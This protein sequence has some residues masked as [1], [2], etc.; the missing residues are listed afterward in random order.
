MKP[1]SF[2]QS[3]F[4]AIA[5]LAG[6]AR[7][8]D[9]FNNFSSFN[10]GEMNG[11][12]G[13]SASDP[14]A[15]A[16]AIINIGGAFGS[17]AASLGYVAP[18]LNDYVY[19]SHAASTPLVGGVNAGFSVL[20][21]VIDSDSGYNEPLADPPL[22]GAETR[23]TFGFRLEN[24]SGA[25]L[26]SLFLVPYAQHPTPE[27]DTA[28]H[29]FSWSTGD[30]TPTTVL[31]P[32]TAQETHAYTFKIDFEPSGVNDVSFVANI[33]G[34][35]FSG[36]LTGLAGQ[37]IGKLGAFWIPLNGPSAPG[38]NFL[39]FDNVSLMSKPLNITTQKYGDFTY[40]TD[41]SA[42]TLMGYTG[43]GGH[44][45][46]PASINGLP[47]TMLWNSLF[48]G[49]TGLTGITIPNSV[50]R[51]SSSAFDACTSLTR[52]TLPGSLIQLGNFVFAGCTSL[53]DVIFLGNMPSVGSE[54]FARSN[55]VTAYYLPGAMDWGGGF[56]GRPAVLWNP[57]VQAG[58]ASFGVGTKGFGFNITGTA[59]IPIVVEASTNPAAG[60]WLPLISLNLSGGWFHFSDPEWTRYPARFYR[61]HTP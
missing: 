38:S 9:Y 2:L 48:S 47:V 12:Q 23:D 61:V 40:T 22:T 45:V 43:T 15:N 14:T 52:V 33:N 5:S 51:I 36:T 8:S 16:G 34:S 46:I 28:F 13:W 17:R 37:M 24:A 39:A 55:S 31:A 11:K 26:F 57:S 42:V 59:N 35:S 25:N 29:R 30:A 19:L 32:L 56:C 20:F 3:A 18:L 53:T 10:L 21:I 41:G 49:H 50:T 44:V 6:Q 4:F 60:P 58:D 54:V 27:N 1:S 7:G